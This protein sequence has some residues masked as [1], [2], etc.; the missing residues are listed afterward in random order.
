[1]NQSRA[2]ADRRFL[3]SQTTHIGNRAVSIRI[4]LISHTRL[5]SINQPG[6]SPRIPNIGGGCLRSKPYQ[7]YRMAEEWLT[8]PIALRESPNMHDMLPQV[9][10][11]RCHGQG[12]CSLRPCKQYLSSKS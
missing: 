9:R 7:R 2:P 4:Q 3:L 12:L 8:E 10:M 5:C 11:L 6:T 1:M